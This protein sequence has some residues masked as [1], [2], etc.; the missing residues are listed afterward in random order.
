MRPPVAAMTQETTTAAV[1]FASNSV[2]GSDAGDTE[3]P[4]AGIL[5]AHVRA[6]SG[7]LSAP[8]KFTT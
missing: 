6:S 5:A 3:N 8:H 7:E 2:P 4:P 1:I